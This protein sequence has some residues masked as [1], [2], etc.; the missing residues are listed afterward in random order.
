M[1]SMGIRRTAESESGGALVE[2]VVALPLLVLVLVATIDFS[3]VFYTAMALTNAARAGAQYGAYTVAQSGNIAMMQTTAINATST[4]GVVAVA[5]RSCECATDSGTFSATTPTAN[6]C[7][8]PP[9]T[10]CPG[11]H[12]VVTVT[13]VTSKTF[14]TIIGGAPGVPSSISLSRTATLRVAN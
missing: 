5:S 14:N 6:D 3:R 10:S 2:L 7:T 9:A 4:P 11:A 8:S 13:V 1:S 12:L